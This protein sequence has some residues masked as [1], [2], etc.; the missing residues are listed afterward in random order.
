M[1]PRKPPRKPP[2]PRPRCEK[3]GTFVR[4]GLTLSRRPRNRLSF[5]ATA[6][7]TKAGSANSTY[8]NL[9]QKEEPARQYTCACV[10]SYPDALPLGMASILVAK[11]GHTVDGAA[12]LE[13]RLQFF[14]RSTVVD[15]CEIRMSPGY[16]HSHIPYFFF[17][18]SNFRF[19][20]L[21]LPT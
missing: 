17:F 15:L 16:Q 21:T 3:P 5:K 20:F 6:A 1:P 8:A 10:L 14:G 2:R 13:M 4:L 19:L 12:R 11:N 7:S 18:F 9:E